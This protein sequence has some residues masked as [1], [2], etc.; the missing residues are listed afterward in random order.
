MLRALILH[1]SFVLPG[2]E[3]SQASFLA[4]RWDSTLWRWWLTV[5]VKKAA[6]SGCVPGRRTPGS[7]ALGRQ[8]KRSGVGAG[9]RTLS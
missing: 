8:T 9:D 7:S 5:I 4:T 3:S 2:L 1:I 6:I